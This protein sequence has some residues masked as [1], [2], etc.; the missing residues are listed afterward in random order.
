M[1]LI[2]LLY[3]TDEKR[4]RKVIGKA[5]EA[6]VTENLEELMECISYNYK[7]D[8]GQ[9]YLQ[10]KNTM[11]MTFKHL[12]DI[13]IEKEIIMVSVKEP[14]AEAQLSVRVLAS[15]AEG[16][17]YIIG[18]AGRTEKMR[19]FLEKSLNKWL[20]VRVEELSDLG[21]GSF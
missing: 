6:I 21:K 5:E 19:I 20:V 7:D 1:I 15:D 2:F 18:D 12:D 9:G 14:S 11:Q 4:I 13:E 3:P 10:L 16:R 8:Y 17:G